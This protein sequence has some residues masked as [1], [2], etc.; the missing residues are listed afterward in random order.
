[1][2]TSCQELLKKAWLSGRDGH[3]S[4]LSEARAWALREVWRDDKKPEYGMLTYIAGKLKK[5]NGGRPTPQA[6][7]Q[8]FAKIDSD[9]LWYPGKSIQETFGPPSAITPTNQAIVAKSAMAMAERGEEPTYAAL[10][11]KNPKALENPETN[12]P[13]S[14]N[15][16]YNI[17]E[18]RCYDDPDD[19]EDTWGHRPL[20]SKVALTDVDIEK[21]FFWGRHML[22]LKWQAWWIFKNIV[23]TDI[24]NS[25]LPRTEKR[26]KEMTLSRKGGKGWRSKK[27]KLK[28]KRLRGKPEARKQKGYTAIKVF[29]APILTRGKLHVEV[30]GEDF[31]GETEEG[32]A[33]LVA[34]VR[35]ALN[36]RFQ[37][38]DANPPK[39]LFTD[40]GQGFYHINGGRITDGFKAALQEH[41]LKTY[42][43]DDASLQPG[44]LQE[45][46]LHET[47]VA[48][49]RNRERKT[50]PPQPCKET[51]LEFTTRIK[52]ICQHVNDNYDV[53]GLCRA[54]PERLQ[55]LVDAKGDRIPK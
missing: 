13:I 17:L 10:V 54:L 19:P 32:A 15:R 16:V 53:D 21:R 20:S 45:L 35:A 51:V 40:R 9:P 49:I 7:G 34:K 24:C 37:G 41:G 29:W 26:L 18:T 2:A 1:M 3:L 14:K 8:M 55:M 39:T 27:T 47:S 50:L 22:N 38:A 44:N 52:A 23:W 31:P 25:L 43:G 48:W 30:L 36:I 11:S 5:V 12:E 6:L 33:I 4:A 42:C 46:L 28:S